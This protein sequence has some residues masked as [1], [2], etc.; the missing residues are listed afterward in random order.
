MSSTQTK[1]EYFYNEY[2]KLKQ[3]T[4]I[5]TK[6]Y[7][8]L[9]VIHKE[10]KTRIEKM[11]DMLSIENDYLKRKRRRRKKENLNSNFKCEVCFRMYS[12]KNSLKQHEKIKH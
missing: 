12:N 7:N 10:T 11:K 2:L 4:S 8:E 5:L 6:Q 3:T 9:T 1:N